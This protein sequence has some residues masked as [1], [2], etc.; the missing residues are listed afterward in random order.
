M[1]ELGPQ[2]GGTVC[3]LIFVGTSD[4]KDRVVSRKYRRYKFKWDG[5]AGKWQL[6]AQEKKNMEGEGKHPYTHLLV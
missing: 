5:L 6:Q 3:V 1:D 4:G 2:K